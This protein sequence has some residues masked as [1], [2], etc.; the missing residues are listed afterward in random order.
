M[1]LTKKLF[2]GDKLYSNSSTI[3]AYE[4]YKKAAQIINK[5]NIALGK[6]KRIFTSMQRS[7]QN[8][9]YNAYEISSTKK[10]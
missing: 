7:T 10:V 2:V 4:I 8:I 3:R 5:T 9:K 6:K 1:S